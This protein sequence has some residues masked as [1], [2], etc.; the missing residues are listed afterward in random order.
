MRRKEEGTKRVREGGSRGWLWDFRVAG[1]AWEE[2][3]REGRH[4]E[5]KEQNDTQQC[6]FL[7]LGAWGGSR[8]WFKEDPKSHIC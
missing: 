6:Q 3:G 7:Q 2:P 8:G 4:F 1:S 5:F